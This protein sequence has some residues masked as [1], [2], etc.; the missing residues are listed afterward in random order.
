MASVALA[1]TAE[2]E[3]NKLVGDRLMKNPAFAYVEN[4]PSLPNVLIYGDSISIAYTDR[5]RTRLEGKANVYRLHTNGSHSGALIE[6]MTRM[7]ETMKDPMLDKPW[8]FGWDV[9][10]FNVGL[11]DLKRLPDKQTSD[12][13]N[14]VEAY[15]ANL[16][17]IIAYLKETAPDATLIFA[18][19][20]PVPKG[21][22]IRVEGTGK[23]YN[24][25]AMEVLEKH[26]DIRIN[27]LHAFTLPNYGKWCTKPNNVHYNKTGYTAQGDEV[28]RIISKALPKK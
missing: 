12:P 23:I 18:T 8:D 1:A 17:K 10:H 9:I 7:L 20:T 15:K 13:I 11:H 3:W 28:A 5:V 24:A 27:D 25:A 26:P 16:E 21:E 2:E 14:S 4:D 6:N 22:K 19:T